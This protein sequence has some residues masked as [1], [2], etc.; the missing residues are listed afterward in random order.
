MYLSD[1]STRISESSL[2][3]EISITT[4]QRKDN[5]AF[6]LVSLVGRAGMVSVPCTPEIHLHGLH[7][8]YVSCGKGEM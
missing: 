6:H 8:L 7:V 4:V 1:L 5:T 3:L 2:G